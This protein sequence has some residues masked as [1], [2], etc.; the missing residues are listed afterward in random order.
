MDPIKNKNGTIERFV[1]SVNLSLCHAQKID[2]DI[3]NVSS[4]FSESIVHVLTV[5]LLMNNEL[6][7]ERT[8]R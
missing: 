8:Y 1:N 2:S 3:L 6:F 7:R 5:F 4:F